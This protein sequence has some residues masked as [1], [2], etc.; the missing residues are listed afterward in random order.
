MIRPAK[1][2]ERI[3]YSGDAPSNN[4]NTMRIKGGINI[5]PN[6]TRADSDHAI[7]SVVVNFREFLQADM[8]ARSRRESGVR[9]MS[10]AL[11]LL[12]FDRER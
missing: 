12:S 4:P 8:N 7:L 9:L 3:T 6:Q 5:V 10:A 1:D 2:S 11:D